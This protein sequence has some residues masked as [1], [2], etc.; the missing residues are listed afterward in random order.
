MQYADVGVARHDGSR[1]RAASFESDQRPLLDS[2]ASFGAAS[3][4]AGRPRSE[5]PSGAGYHRRSDVSMASSLASDE[6]RGSSEFTV[7]ALDARSSRSPSL[8]PSTTHGSVPAAETDANGNILSPPPEYDAHL[9]WGAAPPYEGPVAMAAPRFSAMPPV[10]PA[11]QITEHPLE[12]C[13]C[14]HTRGSKV[15]VEV[16]PFC[17]I[18][19][20]SLYF[21][22]ALWLTMFLAYILHD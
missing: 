13:R 20:D 1:V 4:A 16:S 10:L 6:A 14:R 7:V 22:R 18:N 9:G 2:A 17:S 3:A 15:A 5:T 21:R 11:I 12:R 19:L 8:A